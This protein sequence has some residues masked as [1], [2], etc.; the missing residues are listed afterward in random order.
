MNKTVSAQVALALSGGR[1]AWSRQAYECRVDLS[2]ATTPAW[3]LVASGMV[4]RLGTTRPRQLICFASPVRSAFRRCSRRSLVVGH[5][6]RPPVLS[7]MGAIDICFG[8]RGQRRLQRAWAASPL[9]VSAA[10]ICF[11]HQLIYCHAGW[12]GR[13]NVFSTASA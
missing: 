3:L 2:C 8:T 4:V 9:Q 13:C 12:C 10:L 7:P 5:P 1:S 6:G 11:L